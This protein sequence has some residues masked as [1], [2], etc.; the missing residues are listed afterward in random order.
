MNS[1]HTISQPE[2]AVLEALSAGEMHVRMNRVRLN[3]KGDLLIKQSCLA[4]Y[5]PSIVH[6][7]VHHKILNLIV[8]YLFSITFS[9][10]YAADPFASAK[11]EIVDTVGSGSTAQFALLVIGLCAAGITGFLTKNWGAAIGGFVVGMIFL[12]M[13]LKVVGL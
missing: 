9:S 4:K 1:N 5:M 6:I 7:I 3:D 2:Q 8:V 12:N 13:A 10:A 11:S